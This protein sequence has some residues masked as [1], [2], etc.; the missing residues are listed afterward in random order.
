MPWSFAMCSADV[1]SPPE[2]GFCAC[3]R[4]ARTRR[5]H[6]DARRLLL[7][8]LRIALHAL[9]PLHALN[10][11]LD[12]VALRQ[13][14]QHMLIRVRNDMKDVEAGEGMPGPSRCYHAHVSC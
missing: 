9:L 3:R 5:R 2:P 12:V 11:D 10:D 7:L 6:A 14:K 4:P 1:S 13:D 8:L